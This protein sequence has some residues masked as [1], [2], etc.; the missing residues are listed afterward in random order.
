MT[1]GMA[2]SIEYEKKPPVKGVTRAELVFGCW[3]L[4]EREGVIELI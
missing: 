3:I 2:K 4:E 1:Y